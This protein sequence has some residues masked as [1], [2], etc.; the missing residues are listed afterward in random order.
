MGDVVYLTSFDERKLEAVRA[1]CSARHTK[2]PGWRA[3]APFAAREDTRRAGPSASLGPVALRAPCGGPWD[4]FARSTCQLQI[5]AMEL[6]LAPAVGCLVA[7]EFALERAI[8]NV[9]CG[10]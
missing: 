7:T 8:S 1:T 2:A 3:D 10:G 5:L 6:W 9:W 4:E